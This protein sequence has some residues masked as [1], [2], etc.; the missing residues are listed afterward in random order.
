MTFS[1]F[2]SNKTIEILTKQSAGKTNQI[3]VLLGQSELIN[4]TTLLDNITDVETFHLNGNEDLFDKNW[5]TN[6]FTK[7][8]SEKQFHLLSF[9]QFSY[10]IH[11]IDSS[12]FKT[13]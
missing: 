12:F 2:Y 6:V 4:K 10:L 9:A 8:N 11:Y 3:F 5:F 7:L 1:E 13:E